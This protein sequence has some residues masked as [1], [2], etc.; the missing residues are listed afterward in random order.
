M[1]VT[2]PSEEYAEVVVGRFG[3]PKRVLIVWSVYVAI[4]VLRSLP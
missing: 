2:V 1:E 4:G 3:P